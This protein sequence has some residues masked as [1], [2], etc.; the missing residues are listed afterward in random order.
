M[1]HLCATERCKASI[2]GVD[3][4]VK[5]FNLYIPLFFRSI[6]D[7]LSDSGNSFFFRTPQDSRQVVVGLKAKY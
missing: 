3:D 2:L 6:Y 5:I 1:T 7:M 4:I